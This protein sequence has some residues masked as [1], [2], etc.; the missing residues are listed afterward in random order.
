MNFIYERVKQPFELVDGVFVPEGKYDNPKRTSFPERRGPAL[1]GE[2]RTNTGGFFNGDLEVLHARHGALPDRRDLLH[3]AELELQPHRSADG[4]RPFTIN[5]AQLRIS[6]SFTP[7]RLLQALIQYDDRSDRI[8]MNIRFSVLQRANAG[9][10]VV[11]NEVDENGLRKPSR[12]FV[13]KYS[14]IFDVLR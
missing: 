3:G 4:E 14:R 11:Y 12:E 8:G 1:Y 10:F 2:L 5:A 6:Y 9:L 7:K 13:I